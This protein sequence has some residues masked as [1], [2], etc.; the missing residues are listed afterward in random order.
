MQHG[1]HHLGK[2][3]KGKKS[4]NY[5][6]YLIYVA[7]F[8]SPVALLPQVVNIFITRDVSSLSLATWTTLGFF[9]IL[10]IIYGLAHRDIPIYLTNIL[11]ALLNFAIVLGILLYS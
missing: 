7:A 10:W 5:F 4:L 8:G 3:A 11:I 2:R 9:N 6:D 1:L